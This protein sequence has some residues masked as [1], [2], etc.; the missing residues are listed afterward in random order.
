M[1]LSF[2][3]FF[4]DNLKC[5]DEVGGYC[6]ISGDSC[7]SLDIWDSGYVFK[8]KFTGSD[9][10]VLVPLSAFAYSCEGSSCCL[11]YF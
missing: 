7:A 8:I 5:N 11:L 6:S 4:A 2:N 9:N 1:L 10:Y 3:S